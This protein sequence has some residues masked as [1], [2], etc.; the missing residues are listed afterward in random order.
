MRRMLILTANYTG[1]GHKSV[2]DAL[3][4]RFEN[5]DDMEIR[6]VNGFDLMPKFEQKMAENTY[7]PITRMPGRTWE[8]NYVAGIK[9]KTPVRVAV[10]K[11]IRRRLLALLDSFRPDAILSLH[12]MFLGSVLD[13]IEDA[14][15]HIP[16]AAH[17]VD[18]I[19]IADYWF[20]PRIDLTLAPS[21][22]SYDCT[23]A[24]GVDPDRVVQVG[25]PLRRRFVNAP[26]APP[27]EG[28][29]FTLMSGSEGVGNL[30]EIAELLLDASD[31]RI[32]VVC[33]R[34]H[35]LYAQL[36]EAYGGDPAGRI[37]P[38]GFVEDIEN[39]MLASDLLIMRASPNS[40]LEAVS[41]NVPVVLFG[42][43]AGQELHN[44]DVLVAHGLAKYCPEP[45]DLPRCVRELFDGD[46]AQLEAMRAAQRAYAAE[47]AAEATAKLLHQWLMAK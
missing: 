44:P 22:E 29:V 27:H 2:A 11:M 33:G 35:K 14:G 3:S 17:E 36:C 37:R 46:G 21:R 20:D 8:W 42:Q 28:R 1:H 41:L 31:A 34:N 32:N 25:F 47:D 26:P 6:V 18:L 40:A 45:A 16:L 7:G 4:E 10:S 9:L 13:I 39:V 24:Q 19:D 23:L 30:R 12:P 43:L 15:L 38:M 5:Y